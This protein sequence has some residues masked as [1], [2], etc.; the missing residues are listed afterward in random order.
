VW[1]EPAPSHFLAGL[2]SSEELRQPLQGRRLRLQPRRLASAWVVDHASS[3]SGCSENQQL[4]R[5][6]L[7]MCPVLLQALLVL[8]LRI[9]LLA[10]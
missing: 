4:L 9:P 2:P 8:L 3:R 7:L 6:V 1:A 5:L 10:A